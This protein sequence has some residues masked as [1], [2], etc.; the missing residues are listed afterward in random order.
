MVRMRQR[1]ALLQLALTV[2]ARILFSPMVLSFI[3]VGLT[4]LAKIV[5]IAA[6]PAKIKPT[7]IKTTPRQVT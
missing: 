7:A 1:P 5:L 3:T 4:V 6:I 2:A